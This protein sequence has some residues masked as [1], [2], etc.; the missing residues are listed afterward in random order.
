[1][2]LLGKCHAPWL[3]SEHANINVAVLLDK[4]LQLYGHAGFSPSDDC[5]DICTANPSCLSVRVMEVQVDFKH[6]GDPTIG[7][8]CVE[9]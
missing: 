7:C 3:R 2:L 5:R 1:M 8:R 4:I 6:L 9:L